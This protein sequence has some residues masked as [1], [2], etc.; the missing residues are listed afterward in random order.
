MPERLISEG[1]NGLPRVRPCWQ[2]QGSA[3]LL[4][5]GMS[6]ITQSAN[7]ANSQYWASWFPVGLGYSKHSFYLLPA[8]GFSFPAFLCLIPALTCLGSNQGSGGSSLELNPGQSSQ[9]SPPAPQ[10]TRFYPHTLWDE[11][12]NYLA[13][14]AL[15]TFHGNLCGSPEENMWQKYSW[16]STWIQTLWLLNGAGEVSRKLQ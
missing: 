14:E 12:K 1:P 7:R 9:T 16:N 3:G 15:P 13:P 6:L 4:R 10:Q 2:S 5:A 8:A 11:V